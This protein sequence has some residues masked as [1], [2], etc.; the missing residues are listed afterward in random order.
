MSEKIQ[1]IK[2]LWNMASNMV[3]PPAKPEETP[4]EKQ[5]KTSIQALK[6]ITDIA[7][8]IEQVDATIRATT[9][10]LGNIEEEIKRQRTISLLAVVVSGIAVLL[11]FLLK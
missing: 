7:L 9:N 1:L 4:Q 11:V 6:D 2:E 10:A 5:I 8:K 3:N